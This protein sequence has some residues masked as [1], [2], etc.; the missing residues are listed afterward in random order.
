LAAGNLY[1]WF[2]KALSFQLTNGSVDRV[3]L[4]APGLEFT[5]K[6][7]PNHAAAGQPDLKL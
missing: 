3:V 6:V 5:E 1:C 2:G 4:V 7:M